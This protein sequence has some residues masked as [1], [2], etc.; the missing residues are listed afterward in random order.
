MSDS[1]SVTGALQDSSQITPGQKKEDLKYNSHLEEIISAEAEKALV[2]RWLHDQSEKKYS[3]HNT[4]ITIPVICIST[5]AGT[6]SIGSES[7]FGGS[8]AA[9]VVI[10]MMSL[11]VSV[12]NV[13]SSFFGWAKRSEAHRICS[14]NY[15][16]LHR[17]IAMELALPRDQRVPAKHFL[18]DIRSQI[19]RLNETSPA[20]PDS[21]INAFYVRMKNLKSN[22][23]LPEICNQI[24]NVD[25]YKGKNDE[26]EPVSSTTHMVKNP[27]YKASL[28]EG[29]KEGESKVEANLDTK[30]KGEIVK[31][32]FAIDVKGLMETGKDIYEDLGS[33]TSNKK[34]NEVLPKELLDLLKTKF[35]KS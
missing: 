14:I 21:V 34:I 16:K 19:D 31:D 3:H 11:I 4:F 27:L 24:N 20:I 23:T 1:A 25:V 6:A 35:S 28:L 26:E 30:E 13:V 18:K 7:L 2:L 29:E 15:G 12:L 9:P 17:L 10:G 8:D 32:S 33:L 5:L 22:V